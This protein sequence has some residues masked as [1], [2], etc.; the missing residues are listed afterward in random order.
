MQFVGTISTV[1]VDRLQC[2]A[3][4]MT[5]QRSAY[6]ILVNFGPG[7]SMAALRRFFTARSSAAYCI[8]SRINEKSE[9]H[10]LRTKWKSSECSEW[11]KY[12]VSVVK[13]NYTD[14]VFNAPILISFSYRWVERHDF[15]LTSAQNWT[16]YSTLNTDHAPTDT[17]LC[18]ACLHRELNPELHR[19]RHAVCDLNHAS[20][21]WFS[22]REVEQT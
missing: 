18:R 4:G 11:T 14:N 20:S 19:Q 13:S 3:R 2:A 12:K 16:R 10:T 1:R 8:H 22:N 9:S 5:T 6:N 7:F 17:I 21:H 15:N